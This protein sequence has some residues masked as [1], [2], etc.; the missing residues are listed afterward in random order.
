MAHTTL[1]VRN[2]RMPT[3]RA[4]SGL[5]AAART[6]KPVRVRVRK[7]AST[8]TS[9]GITTS[10]LHW[11]PCTSSSGLAVHVQSSSGGKNP[12]S[13]TSGS[14]NATR[15]STCAMPIVATSTTS[16]GAS[17]R[18]RITPHS[19]SEPAAAAATVAITNASPN[20]ACQSAMPPPSSTA[21]NASAVVP[22]EATAKL[23]TPLARYTRTM[24]AASTAY[25]R[26]CTMPLSNIC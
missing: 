5:A 10:T 24:P 26:P 23:M 22:N 13:S 12:P 19:A 18:R 4:F 15:S 20:G 17:A 9:A 1:A 16:R 2:T 21:M 25:A 3:R 14:A 11:R 8:T 7:S 6:I